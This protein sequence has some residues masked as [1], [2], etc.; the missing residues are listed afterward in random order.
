MV[1]GD[2]TGHTSRN[3][4]QIGFSVNPQSRFVF[5]AY[6]WISMASSTLL[7]HY[8]GFCFSIL[9]FSQFLVLMLPCMHC[10]SIVRVASLLTATL[11]STN[12]FFF[13]F[14]LLPVSPMYKL[15]QSIHGTSYTT[16]FFSSC[17]L[18]ILT[19]ISTSRRVP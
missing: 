7:F 16:P 2:D 12:L 18:G 1:K 3:G 6:L 10:N 5:T 9:A 14:R 15:L 11:C 13:F 17:G 4:L 19:L 8:P